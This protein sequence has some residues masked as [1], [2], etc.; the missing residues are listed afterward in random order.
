MQTRPVYFATNRHW[1]SG[2]A[3]FG[4]QPDTPANRLWLGTVPVEIA[5]DPLVEGKVG[6][7]KRDGPDDAAALQAPGAAASAVIDSWLAEAAAQDAVPLLSIHGFN[8]TFEEA[9]RRAGHLCDFLEAE[10]GLR[11]VPL[12]FS[13]PSKGVTSLAD[14]ER[15]Q[16]ACLASGPALARLLRG[17]AAA[18]AGRP[19]RKPSLIAHSMGARA[20]RC[21]MEALAMGPEA[22]PERAFAQA[23]IIAGDDDTDVLAPAGGRLRPLL[24]LADWTTIGV[25]PRDATLTMISDKVQN[26]RPRLGA[27]GPA[28][29]LPQPEE[30]CYVVDYAYAVSLK[31]DAPGVTDWNYTAHQYYRNDERVRRDLV[32]ALAGAAPEDVPGRHWGKRD[33]RY[34]IKEQE[35]RLYVA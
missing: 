15:D 34:A 23:I 20:T 10:G 3:C 19:G 4:T 22:I 11:L 8:F 14:Y 26:R 5:A 28:P 27:S 35:G 33:E 9:C 29:P 18:A 2:A 1:D 12:A 7:P 17:I 25:Y 13:W 24:T 16:A 21:A 31:P 30:R 6:T 32:A